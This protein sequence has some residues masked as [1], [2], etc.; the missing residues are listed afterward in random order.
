MINPIASAACWTRRQLEADSSWIQPLEPP[1][2]D[3]LRRALDHALS[4]GK[5]LLQMSRSDFPLAQH[6]RRA[7][8]DAV[9][10]TQS[11][12]GIALMRGLPVDELSEEGVRTLCWG[13]GLNLG[14]ARPQGKKSQFMSDVRAEGGQYRS[15]T[16]RGYNTNS[17]LDFHSDACD[18]VA[19]LCIRT[20]KSGGESLASSAVAAH[21]EMLRVRPDLVEILYQ[22]F[23]YSRQGEE[24]PEEPPY[25]EMP[26]FG[27]RDGRFVCRHVRNHIRGAQES[28]PDIPRLTP[29]QLEALDCLD[30]TL[31]REDLCFRMNL[32]P[33]DVQFMNNHVVLHSRTGFVDH[34][35]IEK[36][37][38]LLRLWL[39]IPNAQP[40]PYAWKPFY[41][42][43]ES[44]AVRGGH[45][46]QG[47]TA[48]MEAYEQRLAGEH[49]MAMRIYE[50]RASATSLHRQRRAA[51]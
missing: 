21:N 8:E 30:V 50:D 15:P 42:D 29:L 16:G 32:E 45:R 19:L 13:I 5:S 51:S 17:A 31:A 9:A 25:F 28:F 14:V 39:A 22:P 23:V 18:V 49:A 3:D 6:G 35:E 38:H 10:T 1:A 26:I 47:I 27:Q 43:V 2:V 24:A 12:C 4:T 46:G 48:E 20:A 44:H 40:L 36:R 37:R 33:G 34:D 11:G 7:L 41:K